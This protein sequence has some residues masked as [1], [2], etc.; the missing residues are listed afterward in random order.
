MLMKKVKFAGVRNALK[1]KGFV[2]ALVL[3]LSAVGVSTYI[4]Y[5]QAI[6]KI[7]GVASDV[8]ES[9]S[10][11]LFPEEENS[12]VNGKAEG[13]EKDEETEQA[14]NFIFS[15]APKYMPIENGEV[16]GAFSNGELVKSETLGVW[17]THDGIDIAA[18]IGTEVH[19]MMQGTVS[20]IV[21]DPLWGV[22]IIINHGDGVFGH[23]CGL[24]SATKVTEGQAVEAGDIIG[25]VGDTADIESALQPHLHFGV[26]KNDEWVDPMSIINE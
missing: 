11:F 21:N 26:K 12:A 1:G 16:F 18:L 17:R 15:S 13:I 19:A 22:C 20:E 5:S 3:C 23:Y 10:V 9:D 8:T 2:I 24:D 7:G 25:L 6:S 4:A 14:N